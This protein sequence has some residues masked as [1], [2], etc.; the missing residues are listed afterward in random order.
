M[1]M[2][3]LK[4][5]SLAIGSLIVILNLNLQFATGQT[6]PVVTYSTPQTYTINTAITTLSPTNTGDA[7]VYGNVGGGG[8][9]A[10]SGTGGSGSA[11]GISGSSA[12]FRKPADLVAMGDSVLYIADA[13]N[14]LIR[15]IVLATTVTSIFA[16]GTGNAVA[17]YADGTGTAALFSNPQGIVADPSGSYLYVTDFGNNLIRKI[18]IPGGVVTTLAGGGSPGGTTAGFTNGTRDSAMFSGPSG[19]A[20]DPTGTNLYVTDYTNNLIRKIVISTGVV[21]TITGG[22]ITGNSSGNANGI[23]AA[24]TFKNPVGLKINSSG[25]CLYVADSGNNLIRKILLSTGEVTTIAGG[26]S[27][28]GI[29]ANFIDGIGSAARFYNPYGL[30]IIGDEFLYVSDAT[31]AAIRQIDL[32]NGSVTTVQSG[33]IFVANPR[34][35]AFSS[36]GNLYFTDVGRSSTTPYIRKLLPYPF[37]INPAL[38][39]G[40]SFDT[41]T[42]NISGTPTALSGATTYTIFAANSKG[43]N[44]A[45]LSIAV[46]SA[47]DAMLSNLVSSGGSLN[48]AFTPE[49][50]SYSQNLLYSSSSITVTPTINNAAATATISLNGA[51]P[52]SITSGSAS[53]SLALNV[54]S[55]TISIVVTAQDLITTKTYTITINRAIM[56]PAISYNT[57]KNLA[58]N[59]SIAP[60]APVNSGGTP[61]SSIPANSFTLAGGGAPNDTIHGHADGTGVLATFFHPAGLALDWSGNLYVSD[62]GNNLIRKIDSLGV[63]T[64]LAGGGSAGGNAAGDIYDVPGT[65]A[66]FNGPWGIDIDNTRSK[67]YVADKNNCRIKWISLAADATYGYVINLLGSGPPSTPNNGFGAASGSAAVLNSP[68]AVRMNSASNILYLTTGGAQIITVNCGSG[69]AQRFL[70]GLANGLTAGSADGTGASATFRN[71]W[72]LAFDSISSFLYISDQNNYRI[73]KATTPGG[74]VT[75]LAGSGSAGYVDDTDLSAVFNKPYGQALDNSKANIYVADYTNNLIRIVNIS[76]K[77]VTTFAG[78]GAPYQKTSGRSEGVGTEMMFKNPTDVAIDKKGNV[79]VADYGNNLI[80]K[81]PSSTLTYKISPALPAGLSM[82]TTTGS[83]TGTPTTLSPASNYTITTQN[84]G[85][86][87][88]ATLSLAV[89]IPS[90][91]PTLSNLTADSG[92]F[93]QA[94]DSLTTTYTQTVPNATVATTV[95]PTATAGLASTITVNGTNVISGAQS[96]SIGLNVGS[97]TITTVVTAQDGTTIKSYTLTITRQTTI[98]RVNKFGQITTGNDYVDQYGR[99]GGVSGVGA[100]GKVI[101]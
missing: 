39:A 73:R 86:V 92:A 84:S 95:T 59:R 96:G 2:L 34:G 57:P 17:G 15:K 87:S 5:Q 78:G 85:G 40:L 4:N 41:T 32:S 74:V 89:I 58:I 80:R 12:S 63:V 71:P 100:N 70:G 27:V 76:T 77:V 24:A 20:T 44:K 64:T 51:T 26:Y 81:I 9:A 8:G 83:I 1:K 68:Q 97:N 13:G 19:I 18:S 3:F 10:V 75:T 66:K 62:Y 21:S 55:N 28:W 67:L 99:I 60:L 98:S 43:G 6:A 37:K 72:G 79:Y 49:T 23:G 47:A 65:D 82:N 14:N 50:L 38:P 33:G 25:T 36:T 61:V 42:G 56:P 11:N 22:G 46:T 94:F 7:S 29:S 30:A 35:M 90:T 48:P 16:G 53:S 93:D 45:S 88:T 54:G 52:T 101:P 31:N 91:N 69:Y